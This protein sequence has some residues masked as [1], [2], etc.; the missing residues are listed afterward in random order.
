MTTPLS[1]AAPL[2]QLN[3]ITK[4][5]PRPDSGGAVTVL[6]RVSI[7]IKPREIVALLG[8]SGCGK[9]TILRS[10]AGLIP[11]SSGTIYSSGQR[12]VG[13]NADVAMVFQSFAL[14][15]WLSVKDNVLIG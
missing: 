12:V 8:R 14:L 1:I 4:S 11:P 5:Y 3:E 2:C 6:D 15:P 13:P 7:E 9:S 10:V